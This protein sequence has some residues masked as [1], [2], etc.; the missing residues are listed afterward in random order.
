MR[1]EIRLRTL[2]CAEYIVRTGATVR[3]CA[4]KF[5]VSKSTVH[6]DMRKRLPLIDRS[7]SRAVARVLDINRAQRHLRGGLA[8]RRKCEE[9]RL[10]RD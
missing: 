8:T 10:H 6:K 9:R 5:G 2:E 1:S 4:R 7:L 3:A